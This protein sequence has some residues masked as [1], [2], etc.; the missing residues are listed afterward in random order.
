MKN[1]NNPTTISSFI[2]DF[3][4]RFSLIPEMMK[5][6]KSFLISSFQRIL[7]RKKMIHSSRKKPPTKL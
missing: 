4:F 5:S 2:G 7:E 1:S 6:F 3:A